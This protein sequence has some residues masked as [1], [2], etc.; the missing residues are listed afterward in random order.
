MIFR[1][2]SLLLILTFGLDGFS[3]ISSPTEFSQATEY[4]D[5]DSI[6][7]YCS[8]IVG[9]VQLTANDST[10]LGGFDF[11]WFKYNET[12]QDFTD[13]I[14]S[15][16]IN[17]DSTNSTATGLSNGGYKVVLY[18]GSNTQ[19]Y[20]AWVYQS[21][22]LSV[23]ILF[24]DENDC[25]YLA[26]LTEPY[27]H[28]TSYFNTPYSYFDPLTD[29]SYV[30]QNKINK[31]EWSSTPEMDS[32]RSYNGPFTSVAEDPTDNN[33][34]LPTENTTFSVIVTDRFGCIAE[35]DIEY[36]AIET[37]ADFYWTT[38]DDKTQ[39]IINTGGGETEISGSAPLQV[40]FTNESLNGKDYIWFFGDTLWNNEEDTVFTADYLLEPE[41][42]YYYSAADSGRTYV[43]RMYSESEYGC[44]DSIFLNIKVEPS[45]IEFPNVFTPNGDTK[46]DYFIPKEGYQ[47]IRNFKITIFTQ[48]GQL[49]HEY[50]GDIRDWE[51]WDGKIRNGNREAAEG[52]YFFVVEVMGWD[53]VNYNNNNWNSKQ[54][55]DENTG[56]NDSGTGTETGGASSSF[57]VIRLYR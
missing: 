51:G 34:E 49:V 14:S 4:S 45:K 43:I 44:I 9:E 22:Q 37:D 33:S 42:T 52:N 48:A 57:G 53:N 39:E 50:E 40:R 17:N 41:H 27:Y 2:L 28:T 29:E 35:D 25:D 1:Y 15:F 21:E 31:Y 3:Q 10:D 13:I 11:E 18:D 32:F 36:T 16:S 8:D 23:E 38:L 56:G 26:L 5:S 30:L 6:F 7:V 19:E 20:I 24:H 47:S 46:N 55:E 54:T 12:T